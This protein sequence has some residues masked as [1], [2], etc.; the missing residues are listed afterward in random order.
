MLLDRFVLSK[1][2]DYEY[3]EVATSMRCDA[4]DHLLRRCPCA[5]Q[6]QLHSPKASI[7]IDNWKLSLA[8]YFN[9][10]KTDG[11]LYD[12]ATDEEEAHDVAAANPV[13]H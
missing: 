7:R 1:E 2:M 11:Q 13:S 4:S 3:L 12:L 6:D 9:A 5:A 8:F 10:S